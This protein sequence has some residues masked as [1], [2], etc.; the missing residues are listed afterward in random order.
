MSRAKGPVRFVL[1]GFGNVGS[2]IV[3][4]IKADPSGEI[5]IAAIAARDKAKAAEKAKA[6]G[7]DVPIIDASEAP[8][9]A[10]VA[11]EAA[12]FESFRTVV[13]PTIAAGGHIIAVSVG[14]L[15][16]NLDLIDKARETGATL[17]IANGTLPGL[18]IL[19]AS[20]EAGIRDVLL[21]SR[22]V[23]A[24]LAKEAYVKERGIDLKKAETEPVPVFS[25]S[26]REA[27]GHFPRHFNVAVSIALAGVGLDDTRVEIMAD[28]SLP[29]ARHSISIKADGIELEM[30][31]QNWP[32]PENNRT[33]RIVAPSIIAA[34]RALGS[35]IRVG[36]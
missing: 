16:E 11:V 15:A 5:E 29:G 20:R 7:L 23:P 12:T 10:P 35:P 8:A 1:C 28:G 36:S 27:A 34:L 32:S 2:Q 3:S 33:S 19:R 6:A 4:A 31:S 30:V 13:E 14:A 18:D 24:S 25:G 21:S 22:I 9:H 26:A 17:Q